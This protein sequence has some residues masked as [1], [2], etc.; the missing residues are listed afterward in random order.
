LRRYFEAFALN[1]AGVVDEKT[2]TEVAGIS[3]KTADAYGHLLR[4]LLVV[5]SLPAW[6]SNRLK[7]LVR[8]PKR[9]LVDPALL[10][11]GLRTDAISVLTDGNIL[12]RV[13]DTFVL[14]Q[15]RAELPI[16]SSQP[17]L[18]HLR[19]EQGRR[20]IDIVVELAGQRVVGIEIKADSAPRTDA[21]RH[22]V[23][24]RDE[25]GESFVAGVVLHTGPRTYELADRILAAPICTLWA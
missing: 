22:L 5:D 23:W 16:C 10:A 24:L 1:S 13:L 3:Y 14:A 4:N 12:G 9:Y 11:G 8:G 7:R 20:E 18:Y 2:L 15:L 21:A 6:T 17:R 19:Q 25:L